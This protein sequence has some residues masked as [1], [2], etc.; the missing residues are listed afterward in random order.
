M[1]SLTV[2]KSNLSPEQV[3]LLNLVEEYLLWMQ[4]NWGLQIWL[5]IL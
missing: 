1:E 4:W 2:H 3:T 5:L